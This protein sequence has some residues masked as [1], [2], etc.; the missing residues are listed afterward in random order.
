M[1]IRLLILIA[2]LAA[3]TKTDPILPGA[4]VPVF[5]ADVLKIES[6]APGNIGA[7]LTPAPCDY[8]IDGENQ[9]W[10]GGARIFAGIST[11]SEVAVNKK[12][13]CSGKHIYA[14]LST[15]ELVKVDAATRNLAWAADIFAERNP[16]GGDPFLDIVAAPVVNGGFVYAGGFGGAFCKLRDSDGGKVWCLPIAVAAITRA[17]ENYIFVKTTDGRELAVSINGKA[18][19]LNND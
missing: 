13:V 19:L 12:V 17:T 16:T 6:G 8:R 14:G 10:R 11:E 5:A 2:M 7:D 9:I 18:Y 3:C 15:G 4:R 1:K